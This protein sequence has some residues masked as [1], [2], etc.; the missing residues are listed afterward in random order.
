MVNVCKKLDRTGEVGYNND[1]EKMTI[2][3]YGNWDDIDVQFDD[4]TIIK[5]RIYDSFKKGYM[6]NPMIPSVYGV[7]YFGIG[8]FKSRDEN[9]KQTKCYATWLRMLERCYN[10]K[11]HEKFPTYKGCTVCAEWHNFQVFAEWYYSN[12]YKIEGQRMEL[13]KDILCKDNKVYS[14]ETCVFVPQAI[15]S[16]FVKHDKRRGDFPVGVTKNG[17]K[18]KALV[19]KG[20][21]K[22]MYFGTY[23]TVEEAFQAYKEAKEEY[24][25][26]VA[27]EYKGKIDPRAYEAMMNYEVEIDD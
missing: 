14:P 15:N 1:G 24:I 18:F 5:H 4:G 7:G 26:E 13:D 17:N 2:V 9:G 27:N 23:T 10:A 20:N 22:A 16:L 21:G 8:K 3:R 6:K 11:Y 19:S 12:F 25:K